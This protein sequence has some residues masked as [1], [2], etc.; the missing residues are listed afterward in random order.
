VD[1]ARRLLSLGK[2]LRT[3]LALRKVVLRAR[4]RGAVVEAD[5]APDVVFGRRVSFDVQ[6][7]TRNRLVMGHG[8][9]VHDGV[10]FLLRGGTVD[11]R[12]DVE[13]RRETVLNVSGTLTCLGHNIISYSNVI[14]CAEAITLD[15]YASTNEFVSIIDSTHHHD[16]PAA[17]FYENV[18]SAPIFIGANTWICNKAS[19]L[20]G[21]RIGPNA[22]VASHAVVN[23][24]VPEA[25]V[26]AGLPARVI[27]PRPVAGGALRFASPAIAPVPDEA[28]TA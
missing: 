19:V 27:A 6:H 20:M 28:G 9:R 1:G 2:R 22:V 25:T 17:F 13:V 14:H 15:V 18:S 11:F 21:V 3:A 16:G 4:L 10:T 8:C 23:R 12:E 24:D 26:V 7:G 5:V